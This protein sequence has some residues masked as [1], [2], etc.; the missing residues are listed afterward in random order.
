M[1]VA[2]AV[3]WGDVPTWV[4]SVGTLLAFAIA[5]VLFAFTLR[6][7]QRDQAARITAW[8]HGNPTIL[9]SG[10]RDPYQANMEPVTEDPED[11]CT[12]SE[13]RVV[14]EI[15]I[16][17]TS[18]QVISDVSATLLTYPGRSKWGAAEMRW[19]DIGP[20]EELI[21]AMYRRTDVSASQVRVFLVFTD[22][23]GRHWTRFGPDLR[24]SR[25]PSAPVADE[26]ITHNQV[27]GTGTLPCLISESHTAP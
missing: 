13:E 24:R 10:E 8:V 18:D 1:R 17:N 19:L 20:G 3:D 4:G 15:S 11:S 26:D 21:R 7:R 6:D 22:T 27:Q 12:D 16:R 2:A 23:R 14:I 5:L 25:K 9:R